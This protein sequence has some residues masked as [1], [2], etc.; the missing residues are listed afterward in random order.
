MTKNR[1]Y[2]PIGRLWNAAI[3]SSKV[4]VG[5]HYDAPWRRTADATSRRTR[6]GM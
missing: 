1:E 6:A 4:A 2:G 5:I 3:Q